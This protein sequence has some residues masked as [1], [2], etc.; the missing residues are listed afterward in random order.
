MSYQAEISRA[1]PTCFIFLVDQ[2]TSMID[3]I[4]GVPGNPHK[5]EL[6]ADALNKI[7]QT[8]IVQSSKDEGIRKYFQIGAIG[9]GNQ[10]KSLFS[11]TFGSEEL[12]WIDDLANH[13]IRVEDRIKKEYDGA[14]SV[15]DVNTKFPIWIDP[16]A[17]GRTPM[18]AALTKAKLLLEPWINEH[19]DSYPPTIINLTDGEANDGDPRE[20]ANQIIDLKT[21]DGSVILLTLH[22]SSNQFSREVNF[23]NDTEELPDSPS[24]VMFEMTSPLTENMRNT[25]NQLYNMSLPEGAKGFV[26]N[27]SISVILQALEIGTKPANL[28]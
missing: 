4:M 15:I 25:A 8:L 19:M 21:N 12:I 10:V 6:V 27:G 18:C 23:P 22:V 9:Y 1:N 3:P 26:Y 28:R 20:I 7:I 16:I 17:D 24:K 14:G 5:A 2:S 13:P 11:D